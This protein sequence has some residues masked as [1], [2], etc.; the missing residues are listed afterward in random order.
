MTPAR[1]G[2]RVWVAALSAGLLALG[3]ATAA[4]GPAVVLTA[5]PPSCG[6]PT[7]PQPP[8]V[9]SGWNDAGLLE[10]Q[11]TVVMG[12]SWFAVP[13]SAT[14]ALAD[15]ELRLGYGLQARKA[16]PSPGAAPMPACLME[17]PLTFVVTGLERRDYTVRVTEDRLHPYRPALAAAAAGC[18]ALVAGGIT[19]R[20]MRR[21]QTRAL[22][23][24][25]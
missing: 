5:A 13:D 18:A 14:V 22:R 17:V 7:C 23:S 20:V 19:W 24:D 9:R 15:G 1:G 4:A 21:R 10:V 8:C 12:A 6:A 11:A 2:A 25:A 16:D 3:R